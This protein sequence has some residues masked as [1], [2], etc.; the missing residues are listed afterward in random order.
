MKGARP[1]GT[2]AW[3]GLKGAS[4][5]A[6]EVSRGGG[7]GRGRV[8]AG[9]W[10]GLLG[11]GGRGSLQAAPRV[12]PGPTLGGDGMGAA[13]LRLIGRGSGGSPQ[14]AHPATAQQ[15]GRL[16]VGGLSSPLS[17]PASKAPGL[18]HALPGTA[19]PSSSGSLLLACLTPLSMVR[20][21]TAAFQNTQGKG[22]GEA[23]RIIFGKLSTHT[24][25]DTL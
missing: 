23:W 24:H 22:G 7:A 10:A 6:R 14:S 4:G 17:L 9:G 18:H 13:G 16:W 8:L 20:E 2:A 19:S 15:L 21:N 25:K 11:G 1:G 3:V 5:A 12:S